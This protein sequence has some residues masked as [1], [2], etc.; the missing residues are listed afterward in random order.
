MIHEVLSMDLT[1]LT[2]L[3][4]LYNLIGLYN[5]SSYMFSWKNQLIFSWIFLGRLQ[6]LKKVQKQ[7]TAIS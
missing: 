7:L 6:F 1:Y 5:S 4:I 3:T 2:Y